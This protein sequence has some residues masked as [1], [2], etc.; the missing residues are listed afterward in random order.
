MPHMAFSPF[1]N[2]GECVINFLRRWGVAQLVARGT[3]DPEVPGSMPGAPAIFP[4]GFKNDCEG[5]LPN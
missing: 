3:L 4:Y 2:E 1:T 5:L